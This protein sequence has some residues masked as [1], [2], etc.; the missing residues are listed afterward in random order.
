[1]SVKPTVVIPARYGSR[2]LPGKALA[3]LGGLPMVVRVM[4]QVMRAQEIDGVVVATD[5]DRIDQVVRAHGGQVIRTRSDHVSG[6]DRVGEAADRLGLEH[7]INVQGDEPLLDP[8]VVDQLAGAMHAG[9]APVV[10]ASAPLVAGADN[11][12]RVKVVT[13]PQGMALYFSRSPIP[14]DGPWRLHVGLYGFTRDALRA[15]SRWS[16]GAL[17]RSERL[18]QLRFLENGTPIFVVP[19]ADCGPSVD[20]PEDLVRVSEIVRAQETVGE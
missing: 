19:V 18:E 8:S 20:T 5:D 1:V 9:R 10:T 16:P 11:P 13:D 7:V 12:A 15:F 4:R 3:D 14:V 6:T 17:E 2:R